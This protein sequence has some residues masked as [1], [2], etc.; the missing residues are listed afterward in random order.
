M[1]ANAAANAITIFLGY[2]FRRHVMFLTPF[3]YFR[4]I[5]FNSKRIRIYFL[6]HTQH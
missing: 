1:I 6:K 5:R 4:L 2:I 3:Y